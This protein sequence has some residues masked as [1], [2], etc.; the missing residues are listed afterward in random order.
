MSVSLLIIRDGLDA[1]MTTT[2]SKADALANVRPVVTAHEWLCAKVEEMIDAT[3][4]G[5]EGKKGG[6]LAIVIK[7]RT[8]ELPVVDDVIDR[9]T[10]VGW[11]CT[12]IPH[13]HGDFSLQLI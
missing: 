8:H 4:G 13:P 7:L 10:A 2:T 12:L 1:A 6:K 11:E 5:K 3:R 9:Y